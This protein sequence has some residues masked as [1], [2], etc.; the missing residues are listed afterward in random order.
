MPISEGD[1][2]VTIL[3]EIAGGEMGLRVESRRAPM[4]IVVVDGFEK[5][6]AN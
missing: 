4:L 6:P 5:T 1:A 3:Q 2:R